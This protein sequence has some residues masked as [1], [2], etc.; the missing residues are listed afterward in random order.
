MPARGKKAAKNEIV[1]PQTTVEEISPVEESFTDEDVSFTP[2]SGGLLWRALS[3]HSYGK[4]QPIAELGDNAAAAILHTLPNEGGEIRFKHD[5]GTKRGSVETVGGLRFPVDPIEL[6]RVFTYGGACPTKLN[7]HGCGLNTSLAILNPGNND[8]KLEIKTNEEKVYVVEAPYHD[9]MRLKKTRVYSGQ[10]GPK[11]GSVISFPITKDRFQ[12]LYV[13]KQAK[14]N[15]EDLHRRIQW[16]IAHFWMMNEEV[17]EGKIRLYYNDIL[18]PP[19][20]LRNHTIWDEYIE[21][22]YNSEAELSTGASIKVEQYKLNEKAKK[23]IPGSTWFKFGMSYNGIFLFKNGR[24]IEEI[25]SDDERKLYSR[26]LGH[27]P[28]NDHNGIIILVNM[29]GNQ[30]QL[31]HTTP[32]KNRFPESDLLDE[33]VT[34]VKYKIKQPKGHEHQSEEQKVTTFKESLERSIE[35]IPGNPFPHFKVEQEKTFKMDDKL[36]S[37]KLDLVAT[38]NDTNVQIFEAKDKS[39]VLPEH[40]QQ[41]HFYWLLLKSSPELEGKKLQMTLLCDLKDDWK[42]HENIL[43]YISLYSETGFTFEIM[44][45]SRKKLL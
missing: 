18:V 12:D 26:F 43:H 44:N 24:F 16:Q 34:K 28:H 37:P 29:K 4:F 20:S 35:S 7:E 36:V 8:W 41:L 14:M 10:P 9:K 21:D 22:A 3:K 19:F 17:I 42:P 11:N 2:S 5:F 23:G 13:S 38:Y 31:P 27:A 45:Y 40:I 15:D 6:A 33:L 30:E 32:T 39:T 25:H 1:V